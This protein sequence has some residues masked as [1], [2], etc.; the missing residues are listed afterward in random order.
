MNYLQ[1]IRRENLVYI[2]LN[3]TLV[4]GG[5]F[6]LRYAYGVT[7]ALPFTHEVILIIL[8]SIITI[9]ITALLLNKQT[10]VELRKEENVKF[11]ELKTRVYFELFE[12]IEDIL[13]AG[14]SDREDLLRM[15]FLS[16]RL[17][18]V[19]GPEVLEQYECFLRAFQDAA[20]DRNFAPAEA[21]RI[22]HE[23]ARLSIRIRG[24]LVGD[25]DARS[26]Y[27]PSRISSQIIENSDLQNLEPD[28]EET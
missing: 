5:Y 21:D 20:R 26:D 24:D 14:H 11:L 1:S 18:L 2:L 16:H 19:A 10:E 13:I 4:V 6:F 28:P 25:L 8:G 17:S 9:L 27:S 23:L 12:K 7:D 3:I 15:H 22:S